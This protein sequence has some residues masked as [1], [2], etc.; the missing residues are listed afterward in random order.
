MVQLRDRA[1]QLVKHLEPEHVNG[2]EG[3]DKIFETLEQSSTVRLSEK[4]RVDWH[5]KRLVEFDK[6]GR[7][8]FGKLHHQG[9][10]LPRS[11]TRLGCFV[12]HGRT[13]LCWSSSRPCWP[14]QEG[15]SHDQNACGEGGWGGDHRGYDGTLLGTGGRAGLSHRPGRGTG[16][17]Q[18]RGRAFGAARG[19][20]LSLQERQAGPFGWDGG[21]G[22]SYKC[23]PWRPA[24]RSSWRWKLWGVWKGHPWMFCTLSMRR[25]P[26]STRPNRKWLRSRS[27]GT[28]IAVPR[29]IPRRATKEGNA[30]CVMRRATTPVTAQRSKQPWPRTLFWWRPPRPKGM[31][32]RIM[33]GVFWKNFVAANMRRICLRLEHTWCWW[34]AMR[35]ESRYPQSQMLPPLWILLRHG[36]IWRSCQGRLFWI[37]D[38][39]GMWLVCSGLMM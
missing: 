1:A 17:R 37:W 16:E 12:D 20:G 10:P 8:E 2:K 22:D 18:S 11:T 30:S 32:R 27:C 39:C 28:F 31:L 24:R 21:C 19:D 4:H 38:V 29:A 35:V 5:R 15:Q 36:G 33:N 7:W 23:L 25:S 14:Y 9:W 3:L 34:V 13:F 6:I 26:C